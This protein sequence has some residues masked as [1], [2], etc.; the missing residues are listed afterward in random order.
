MVTA[1]AVSDSSRTDERDVAM[2]V[3]LQL[4]GAAPA[5]VAVGASSLAEL[6]AALHAY[7]EAEHHPCTLRWA[8]GLDAVDTQGVQGAT[9]AALAPGLRLRIMDLAPLWAAYRARYLL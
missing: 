8:R 3:V 1:V 7:T 9:G 4:S 2:S 6:A 5:D